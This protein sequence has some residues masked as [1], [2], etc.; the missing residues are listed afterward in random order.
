MFKKWLTIHEI[1]K[2]IE[3]KE[4]DSIYT[5]EEIEYIL[6]ENAYLK[7]LHAL[8]QEKNQKNQK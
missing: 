2:R 8:V 6:A 3:K 1:K 5:K 7:K 4:S